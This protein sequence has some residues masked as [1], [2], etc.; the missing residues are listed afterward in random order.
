MVNRKLHV[1]T[2]ISNPVR[3]KSR[4]ELYR[5]FEQYMLPNQS[6][7]FYT[8]EMAFGDR[9]WAITSADNPKHVQLRSNFEI[10]HKENMLNIA[11]H[12]LPIDWQ[13]VAW[14]DADV[15]FQRPDW[16]EETIEQLQHYKFVQMFSHS[17][18][19][20]PT[21]EPMKSHS[22][23][24]HDWYHQEDKTKFG[25][26]M[27]FGHPGYAWAATRDALDAVGGLIDHAILGS[28]DHHMACALVGKVEYSYHPKAHPNYI[29]MCHEWQRR[30]EK[31]IKQSVGYVSG[32]L[33]HFW[34]GSK[35]NRHYNSRWDILLENNYNPLTDVYKDST[36]LYRLHD[37]NIGLR[38]GL[39]K[40][41]RSR[42]EDCIYTGEYKL[43]P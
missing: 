24:M 30:C 29:A 2:C 20:S 26:Y 15:L 43:L 11:L 3:Y 31:Y 5:K 38:D 28:S 22:G 6:I 1:I 16:A 33:T 42:M 36:G 10:W 21:Y 8:V 19:V 12:R 14:I 23:F 9:P 37:D 17:Q 41:S 25:Q 13:Y 27:A 4:Y 40:Y 7:E 18:D 35:E 34:H 39:K 32:G